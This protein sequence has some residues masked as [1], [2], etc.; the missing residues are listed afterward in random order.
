MG[1]FKEMNDKDKAKNRQ[2]KQDFLSALQQT[3]SIKKACKLCGF[4]V[5]HVSK[6][7]QNDNWFAD[8]LKLMQRTILL[9]LESLAFDQALDG[10]S[11]QIQF[12]LKAWAPQRYAP[13]SSVNIQ[14]QD[15]TDVRVAGQDPDKIKSEI[16][17][18]LLETIK[19]LPGGHELMGRVV[20]DESR[21]E[22]S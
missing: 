19:K 1:G 22:D 4:N 20:N 17:D 14:M 18:K 9:E 16:A 10:D 11:R 13:N 3:K 2:R 8:E 21:K 5:T 6:W 15:K 7:A 12:L